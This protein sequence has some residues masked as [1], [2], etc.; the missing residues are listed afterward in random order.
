MIPPGQED[1]A[2]EYINMKCIRIDSPDSCPSPNKKGFPQ[3]APTKQCCL[4]EANADYACK[5]VE[6]VE[7]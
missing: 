5:Q 7:L 1:V 3:Y 4:T 6:Y 2:S